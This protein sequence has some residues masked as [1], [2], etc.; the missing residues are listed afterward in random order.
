MLN[1]I[2]KLVFFPFMGLY[3]CLYQNNLNVVFE[4]RSSDTSTNLLSA[5][6]SPVSQNEAI[7]VSQTPAHQYHQLRLSVTDIRD[8]RDFKLRSLVLK[9]L[10]LRGANAFVPG[11]TNNWL[12]A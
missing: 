11:L 6:W 3:K 8:L 7:D 4:H 12:G 10:R 5:S 2:K 9:G 1:I